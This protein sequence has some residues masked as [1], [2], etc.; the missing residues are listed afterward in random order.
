MGYLGPHYAFNPCIPIRLDLLF[1]FAGFWSTPL[2]G[3]L[4]PFRMINPTLLDVATITGLPIIGEEPSSL[5]TTLV[6]DLKIMFSKSASSYASFL[7]TNKKKQEVVSDGEHNAF[8]LYWF[9][10]YFICSN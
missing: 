4:F 1:V 5:H 7:V 6:E 8:F 10:K 3:F 9:C 2:N